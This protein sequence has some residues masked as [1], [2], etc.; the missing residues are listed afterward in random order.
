METSSNGPE[1]GVVILRTAVNND[2][3]DNLRAFDDYDKNLK[4]A[5]EALVELLMDTDRE[6]FEI[7]NQYVVTEEEICIAVYEDELNIETLEV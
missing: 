2:V 7:G 6:I 4:F 3:V 5:I 1:R